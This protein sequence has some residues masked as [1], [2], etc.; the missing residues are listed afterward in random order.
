MSATVLASVALASEVTTLKLGGTFTVTGQTGIA[1]GASS[2]T[3]GTFVATAR[4]DAG[5]WYLVK[6]GRTDAHGHFKAVIKPSLRGT[7]TL[8]LTT[9]DERVITFLLRVT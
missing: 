4:R 6:R 2:R 7:Y 5:P 1:P 8:R 9:P 3:T